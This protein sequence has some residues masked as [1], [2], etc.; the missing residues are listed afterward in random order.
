MCVCV[1]MSCTQYM[2]RNHRTALQS[3]FSPETQTEAVG[4]CSSALFCP[5]PF[6]QTWHPAWCSFHTFRLTHL[7]CGCH[8]W[9]TIRAFMKKC[10][11]ETLKK[12]VFKFAHCRYTVTRD[13]YM[14]TKRVAYFH[15]SR[16]AVQWFFFA[17]LP[18]C[19]LPF[20]ITIE[21]IKRDSIKN[22]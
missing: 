1:W 21:D 18:P 22:L 15:N 11:D 5:Q 3:W 4:F 17:F 14:F 7:S 6:R 9:W 20:R 19:L 13:V 12:L 16:W 8:C 10:C 2:C